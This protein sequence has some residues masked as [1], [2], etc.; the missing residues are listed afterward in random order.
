[1]QY[2]PG[3][4][5]R[6]KLCPAT[7]LFLPLPC[8]AGANMSPPHPTPH[9]PVGSAASQATGAVH[10]VVVAG[11]A[12]AAACPWP[13]LAALQQW[14]LLLLLNLL[15]ASPSLRHSCEAL[16]PISL[17]RF[18]PGGWINMDGWVGGWVG[19]VGGWT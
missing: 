5:P 17:P 11:G 15:G 12:V 14:D 3:A 10:G 1:M 6:H 19:A 7:C 4:R 16:T 9:P 13:G 18:T 2:R 8:R